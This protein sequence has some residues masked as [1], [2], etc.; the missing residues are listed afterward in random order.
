MSKHQFILAHYPEAKKALKSSGIPPL[1]ALA[2]AALES[3]WGKH[4]PGNMLFGIKIGK[5]ANYGGW[6]GKKQLITTTEYYQFPNKKYQ[7]IY[8]AYPMRTVSGNWKYKIKDEFRAYDSIED[9]FKDWAGLL[10]NNLC[11]RKAFQ[12]SK[13]PY[14]FALAIA[15]AGYATDPNY[16]VKIHRL[17]DSIKKELTIYKVAYKGL[18]PLVV[19]SIGIITIV[20]YFNY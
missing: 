13:D 10:K 17:M 20:Y 5:G 14:R 1:F 19:I 7:Y 12:Y 8:P 9:S 3:G 11:Y 15:E 4:A 6:N 18:L 2:Q 16:V